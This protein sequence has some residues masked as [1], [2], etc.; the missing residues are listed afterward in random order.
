MSSKIAISMI[1]GSDAGAKYFEKLL[2][3]LQNAPC[4]VF[5]TI[6]GDKTSKL[7]K[8]SLKYGCFVSFKKWTGN[9]AEMRNFSL[10]QVP[11]SYKYITWADV[12][13]VFVEPDQFKP[14]VEFMEK[15]KI[16]IALYNYITSEKLNT[17]RPVHLWKRGIAKWV[18][19]IHERL[20]FTAETYCVAPDE[21][22]NVYRIHTKDS[23]KDREA[24]QE[25]NF[26]ILFE[27][28]NNNGDQTEPLYTH[29]IGMTYMAWGEYDQAL[30]F[31]NMTIAK[32]EDDELYFVL[33]HKALCLLAL[34]K[35]KEALETCME[36]IKLFPDWSYAYF[37]LSDIMVKVSVKDSIG[38]V[39]EGL[40]RNAPQTIIPYSRQ[41]ILFLPLLS[42]VTNY[43]ELGDLENA[44]SILKKLQEYFPDEKKTKQLTKILC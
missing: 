7:E 40:K 8:L 23:E 6:T 37:K 26:K 1:I 27:E 17:D 14:L 30:K 12:D 39:Y 21:G 10:E 22:F 28:Y 36:A 44:K 4:D 5:V 19:S 16:D 32:Y 20:D 35:I 25:R 3:S 34:D 2:K 9:F 24:S 42:L 13:D 15:N 41:E 11:E 38:W 33:C 18:G 31:L 29:Y 43:Y